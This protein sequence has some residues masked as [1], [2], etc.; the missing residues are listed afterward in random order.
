MS[1][2]DTPG[3]QTTPAQKAQADVAVS[4]WKAYSAKSLPAI[5]Y[6]KSRTM[7]NLGSKDQFAEGTG[8]VDARGAFGNAATKLD[9]DAVSHG[10]DL[11]SDKGIFGQ[12]NLADNKAQAL[13]LS[14]T[15]ADAAVRQ[16]Y[17][18]GLG[19]IVTVGQ[20]GQAS[21]DQ[22]LATVADLSGEQA[23]QT[24]AV[25]EED[26]AGLGS[27]IGTGLGI[28]GGYGISTAMRAPPTA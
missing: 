23:A 21:S 15:D 28:P 2:G 4:K 6:W 27:A 10:I 22:G 25:S 17:E 20:G 18:F 19:D 16:Q 8:N 7:A 11:G 13:G 24:A 9:T 12:V 26:A 14:K 3:V 1:G 5:N